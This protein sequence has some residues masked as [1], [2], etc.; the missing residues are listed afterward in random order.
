[1]SNENSDFG[2][3]SLESNGEK[4]FVLLY[5][6]RDE[7]DAKLR[8]FL[9]RHRV[10]GQHLAMP[11]SFYS[12]PLLRSSHLRAGI[13]AGGELLKPT[14]HIEVQLKFTPAFPHYSQEV[15]THL[16]VDEAFPN[17]LAGV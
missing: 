11:L 9:I 1:M 15:C 17:S 2:H 6:P 8:A 16:Y 5:K 4:Q 10:F 14:L 12:Q 3:R 7:V 13:M